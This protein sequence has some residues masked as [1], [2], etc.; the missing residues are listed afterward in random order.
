MKKI[1]QGQIEFV[2]NL[3]R[4][5]NIGVQDFIKTQQMFESLPVVEVAAPAEKVEEKAAPKVEKKV[6]VKK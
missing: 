4:T 3:L 6:E 1:N 5:Y 2:L